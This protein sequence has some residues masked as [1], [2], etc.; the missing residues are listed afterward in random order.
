ML[1]LAGIT[2][3]V[4]LIS[5]FLQAVTALSWT[6]AMLDRQETSRGNFYR[7]LVL[8][9]TVAGIVLR[10]TLL[11][12]APLT[13]QWLV[14]HSLEYHDLLTMEPG[15]AAFFILAAVAGIMRNLA[16]LTWYFHLK[17]G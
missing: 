14:G 8:L 15:T 2:C 7:R 13:V 12:T 6:K 5:M 4:Y 11:L 17:R 1:F 9:R 10:A 16:R 3:I